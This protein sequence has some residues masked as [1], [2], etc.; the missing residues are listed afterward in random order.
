VSNSAESNYKIKL[1]TALFLVYVIWGSTYLGVKYALQTLPPL[2]LTTVRFLIA[3]SLMFLF[4]LM[5]GQK[6]PT[7]K[8]LLGSSYLGILM[9]GIGTGSLAYAILY[10]PSGIVALLVAMLPMWTFL[11]DF[12]FFSKTK[13]PLLS[14]IGLLLGAIGMIF[15]LNPFDATNTVTLPFFPTLVVLIGCISWAYGSLISSNTP[16]ANGTQTTAIQLFAGGLLAF[17]GS[18]FLENNQLDALK[19]IDLLTVNSLIY[20][21][22]IGSIVGFTSYVWLVN[23]A[24]PLLTSTYA[25]V[26]P[27]VALL[28]GYFFAN[29][30]LDNQAMIASVIIVI[31]VV[32][33][34]LGGRSKRTHEN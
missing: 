25:Y 31:A 14:G 29:E 18:L 16:Q 26:N 13:P 17:F 4:T 15:L 7:K 11:L 27:V 34:T 5:R 6:Y 33:M 3:G 1:F 32:L 30:V 12:F 21:I 24:P 28:L 9:S 2:L 20:L 10:I 23:N 19:N 8:Q 22:F